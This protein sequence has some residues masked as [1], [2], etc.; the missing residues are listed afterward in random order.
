MLFEYG[1]I[2][3]EWDDDKSILVQKE[4]SLT[5][6]EAASVFFD[7]NILIIEDTRPYEEYRLFAIGFSNKARLLTVCWTER[8]DN[9][10]LIT[11]FKATSQ[12]QQRYTNGY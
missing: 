7:E 11:A 4:H 5:M 9:I 10:R 3:F 2:I 6:E 1:G 12:Q 8:G